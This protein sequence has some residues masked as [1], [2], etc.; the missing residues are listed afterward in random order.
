ME[1]LLTREEFKEVCLERD[2]HKCVLCPA[3]DGL[4]VHHIIERKLWN[5]GGY[6]EDNGV[7]VCP[8][9]HIEVEAGFVRPHMLWISIG[10]RIKNGPLPDGFDDNVLCD[11]WGQKLIWWNDETGHYIVVPNKG[12]EKF[13]KAVKH[14][15][16]M[17]R[18]V[19][20]EWLREFIGTDEVAYGEIALYIGKGFKIGCKSE[21]GLY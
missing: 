1:N 8:K 21:D 13:K 10:V 2:G 9:C 14:G 16:G 5:D 6:Y 12:N 11:K 18:E 19:S 15:G 17:V 3:I 4:S 20:G 7:T